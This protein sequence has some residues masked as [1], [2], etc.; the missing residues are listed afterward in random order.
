MFQK[1]FFRLD[2]FKA[3]LSLSDKVLSFSFL[4]NFFYFCLLLGYRAMWAVIC[5][6]VYFA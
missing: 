5:G 4:H 1:L 2:I 3:I 6:L